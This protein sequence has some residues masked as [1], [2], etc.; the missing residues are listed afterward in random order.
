MRVICIEVIKALS[1]SLSK[2]GK[3]KEKRKFLCSMS[4]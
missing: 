3:G 2:G 1:G 4:V